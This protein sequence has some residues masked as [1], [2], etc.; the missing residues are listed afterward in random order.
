MKFVYLY[1][2]YYDSD[3]A[4]TRVYTDYYKAIDAVYAEFG[5]MVICEIEDDNDSTVYHSFEKNETEDSFELSWMYGDDREHE[6]IRVEK[7]EVIE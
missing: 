5:R 6:Y 4:C 2:H 1:T 3:I 7:V